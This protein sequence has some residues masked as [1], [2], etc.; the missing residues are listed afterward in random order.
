MDKQKWVKRYIGVME[1][2][3]VGS[4]G[5]G[6]GK[7]GV[8]VSGG[9]DS[10]IIAYF[11]NKYFHEAFFLTLNSKKGT[12]LPFV[13]ILMEKLEREAVVVNVEEMNIDVARA[14]VEKMLDSALIPKNR[15]QVALG[16]VYYCL[17]KQSSKLGVNTIFTGQGPDILL[18]GYNKYTVA[19][20]E[21][22]ELKNE[23]VKDLPLLE[24]DKKRDGSIGKNWGINIINPYLER[25]FVDFALSVPEGLLIS[26]G[27]EKFI[28]RLVGKVVVL[29]ERIVA[30]PKKAMQYSTGVQKLLKF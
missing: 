25:Q 5:R 10:S 21:G 20:S 16:L 19:L 14:E 27:I 9:I 22:R 17:F 18:G 11:V 24:V 4:V 2:L 1:K 12:D 30:R 6:L 26:N 7:V 13:K 3:F 29:P 15:M 28:S 23:I 8:L